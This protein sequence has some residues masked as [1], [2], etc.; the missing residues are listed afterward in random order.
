MT[1]TS[2]AARTPGPDRTAPGNPSPVADLNLT[3]NRALVPMG[4]VAP[5]TTLLDWLRERG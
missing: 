4:E 5:H 1:T 3:V 2:S